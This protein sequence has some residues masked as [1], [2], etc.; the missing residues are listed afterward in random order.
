MDTTACTIL[1][2]D[3]EEA[4]LDLLEIVLK[5]RGY[6]SLVR[7][8]DARQAVAEFRRAQ[9][10]LVL[11]DLHMPHRTGFEVLADL[12]ALVPAD[13][14]LPVIVLTA[15][16]TAAARERA[17]ANGAS[18][19]VTK[20]FDRTEVLLRVRNLL[21]TRLLYGQERRAREA[22]ERAAARD[23][24]LAD[25]SR[26]LSASFDNGTA[27]A[28]LRALL[29]SGWGDICVV[30][31]P[32]EGAAPA[33]ADEPTGLLGEKDARAALGPGMW[34][35]ALRVP[36]AG[37][38][39]SVGWLVVGRTVENAPFT[40]DDLAL[41]VE[42]AR[43]FQA[44]QNAL[45][46]RDQVLAVVA[47][48]LRSPL[49]AV[50]FE[51]EMLRLDPVAPLAPEDAQ[52]L[53]RVEQA[54]GRMDALIQDLLDVSRASRGVLALDRR[55]LAMDLLMEEAAA[56]VRPLVEAQ[57]LE[58]RVQ[59]PARL[60]V[61]QVDGARVIQA[62]SN[63]V[64]NAAKFTRHQG[65]VTLGWEMVD[66]ALRISVTDEGPGIGPEQVQ[67]IFGAFWQ[68]RHADRRGLGLGLAIT[69]AIAEAHGGRIWVESEPGHGA[70]FF[71]TLPG[72]ASGSE[73]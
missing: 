50:R 3:D 51:V 36:L 9:P 54:V 69:R 30:D 20:P 68:A 52:T 2:V 65:R 11:L 4:N 1:L 43:A 37:S 39:P 61:L 53:G 22:A 21:H 13:E 34:S 60:P 49:T 55:P 10:D 5:P 18:D 63:L 42:N 66:G 40:E 64:G 48:D 33:G 16:I 70:T 23:R 58:F 29:A 45:A 62:I 28:Q 8:S 44:A 56:T 38:G 19:F 59:G 7:V 57:R 12:H 14:Y 35:S 32:E 25:A 72:P 67:H 41:A 6:T 27:L 31:V 46:A 71:F 26:L 24:L 47:H 15:D 17:L 73:G